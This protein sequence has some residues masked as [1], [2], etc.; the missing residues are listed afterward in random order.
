MKFSVCVETSA[1]SKVT[2]AAALGAKRKGI[3]VHRGLESEAAVSATTLGY[4]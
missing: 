4:E 3:P 2:R 1:G